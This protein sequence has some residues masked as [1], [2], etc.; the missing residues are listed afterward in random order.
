MQNQETIKEVE[1]PTT[2]VVERKQGRSVINPVKETVEVP[3]I[4]YQIKRKGPEEP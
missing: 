3:Q 4:T 1:R 2:E